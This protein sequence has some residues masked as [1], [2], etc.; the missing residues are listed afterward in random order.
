VAGVFDR[1]VD[2][3]QFRPGPS[4]GR[5]RS[6]NGSGADVG[7]IRYGKRSL[8]HPW[9]CRLAR[10]AVCAFFDPVSWSGRRVGQRVHAERGPLDAPTVDIPVPTMPC[11]KGG[12]EEVDRRI[13]CHL[14]SSPACHGRLFRPLG[15]FVVQLFEAR[16]ACELLACPTLYPA[17]RS[18]VPAE[19]PAR[20]DVPPCLRIS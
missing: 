15:V 6:W 12:G 17:P 4:F 16:D 3:A 11:R 2:V 18:I 20:P 7:G 5:Q 14:P 10:Q 1:N 19:Y 8:C 13:C 9:P